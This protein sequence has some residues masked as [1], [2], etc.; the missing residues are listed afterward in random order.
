MAGLLAAPAQPLV[1]F[2]NTGVVGVELADSLGTVVITKGGPTA[3][4][5]DVNATVGLGLGSR[6]RSSE[7]A[8]ARLTPWMRCGASW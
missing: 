4:G 6:D 7:P 8:A 3:R 5:A 1:H 2:A